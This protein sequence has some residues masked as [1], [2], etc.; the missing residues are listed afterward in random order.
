MSPPGVRLGVDVE[1]IVDVPVPQFEEQSVEVVK[2]SH[3]SGCSTAAWSTPSPGA[4]LGA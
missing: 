4:H 1:K 3:G 2:K